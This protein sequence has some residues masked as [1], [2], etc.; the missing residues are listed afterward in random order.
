MFLAHALRGAADLDGD[1]NVSL[2]ELTGFTSAN[3]SA[4]VSQWTARQASQSPQLIWGGGEAGSGPNPRLLS[5][6]GVA[7]PPPLTVADLLPA[8]QDI[9]AQ[10]AAMPL[11]TGTEQGPLRRHHLRL[12]SASP[13]AEADAAG[14]ARG[15]AGA[16]PA[17]STPAGAGTRQDET[18]A[19]SAT[20]EDAKAD[21]ATAD[22]PDAD[23]AGPAMVA[24]KRELLKAWAERDRLGA[25]WSLTQPARN[26]GENVPHLWKELQLELLGYQRAI[27]ADPGP[28]AGQLT[29]RLTALA[30]PESA[31]NAGDGPTRVWPPAQLDAQ[32]EKHLTPEQV[33]SLAL[34]ALLFPGQPTSYAKDLDRLREALAAETSKSLEGWLKKHPGDAFDRCGV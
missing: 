7:K 5:L 19:G 17:G 11:A 28:A 14:A 8:R 2:H 32:I 29:A 15:D 16:D 3:V 26:P 23:A 6:A 4:W 20:P 1:R 25:D 22:A 12:V 18:G 27:A 24:A 21:Q 10:A 34:A 33:H 30:R 13:Q 9:P 31:R